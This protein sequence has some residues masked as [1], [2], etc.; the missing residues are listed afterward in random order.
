MNT[1][2]SRMNTDKAVRV[3]REREFAASDDHPVGDVA[4]CSLATRA[5]SVFIRS[6]PCSSVFPGVVAD[7]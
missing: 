4:T 1:D 6:D 5:S 3:G 7:A 2:N